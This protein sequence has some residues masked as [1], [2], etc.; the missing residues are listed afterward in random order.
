[1]QPGDAE[2]RA[3]AETYKCLLHPTALAPR[4]PA[5]CAKEPAGLGMGPAETC[6]LS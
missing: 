1:M 4:F 3:E 2:S 5:E 6:F